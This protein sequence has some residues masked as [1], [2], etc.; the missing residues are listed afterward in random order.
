M[1]RLLSAFGR[2][3]P[4]LP[5]ARLLL[6]TALLGLAGCQIIPDPAPDATRFYVLTGPLP[7]QAASVTLGPLSLGLKAVSVAPYLRSR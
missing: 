7:A 1:K 6:G 3:R 5:I 4:R 2:V